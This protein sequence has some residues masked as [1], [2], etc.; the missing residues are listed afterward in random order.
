MNKLIKFGGHVNDKMTFTL[1][2]L[3]DNNKCDNQLVKKTMAFGAVNFNPPEHKCKTEV[4][5]L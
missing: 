4:E 5:K 3:C 1:Y 2:W